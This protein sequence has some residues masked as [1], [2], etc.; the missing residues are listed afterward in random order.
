M[1]KELD[2]MARFEAPRDTNIGR[3]QVN[4]TLKFRGT[5]GT[6]Q[7]TRIVRMPARGPPPEVITCD[8]K[9]FLHRDGQYVEA[10][11]W[12]IINELDA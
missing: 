11:I 2:R 7:H 4:V 10:I 9:I 12:P 1:N 3:P 6:G 8:G 5:L